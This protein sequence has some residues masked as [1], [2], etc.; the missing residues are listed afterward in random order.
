MWA[1][2][3]IMRRMR[4]SF[5]RPVLQ[6]VA[7]WVLRVSGESLIETRTARERLEGRQLNLLAFV[8]LLVSPLRSLGLPIPAIKLAAYQVEK[9]QFGILLLLTVG[10]FG[11]YEHFRRTEDEHH[12]NE[13][14]KVNGKRWVWSAPLVS[15]GGLQDSA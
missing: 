7:A 15:P 10:V 9:S 6:N 3:S 14:Y 5:L 13:V 8:D 1:V 4:V 12:A 11:P 2:E